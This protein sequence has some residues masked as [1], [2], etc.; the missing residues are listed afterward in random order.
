MLKRVALLGLFAALT[1]G[2]L[3][4]PVEAGEGGLAALMLGNVSS[5]V[6]A[7]WGSGGYRAPLSP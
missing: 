6:A 4:S 2:N 7:G 1:P 5:S 3:S